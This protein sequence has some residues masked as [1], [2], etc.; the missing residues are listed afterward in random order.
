MDLRLMSAPGPEREADWLGVRCERSSWR[1]PMVVALSTVLAPHDHFVVVARPVRSTGRSPALF[2]VARTSRAMTFV[3]WAVTFAS[4]CMTF[5][6]RGMTF[7]GWGMTFAGWG[8]T[9]VSRGMTF[10]GW[11]PSLIQ[12]MAPDTHSMLIPKSARLVS[13]A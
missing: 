6:S 5:A 7:V 13:G 9:F 4:R 2:W 1:D 3:G 11:A 10:V 8:M 12:A